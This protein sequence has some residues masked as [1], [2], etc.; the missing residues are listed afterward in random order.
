MHIVFQSEVKE[1]SI[2]TKMYACNSWNPMTNLKLTVIIPVL[3]IN[4]CMSENARS[5]VSFEC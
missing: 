5:Y 3:L 1:V 4:N 2:Y